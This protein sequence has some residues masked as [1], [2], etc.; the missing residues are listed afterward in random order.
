MAGVRTFTLIA[1]LG[2]IT[3]ILTR[4]FDNPF[5]IPAFGIAITALMIMSNF[6]KISKQPDTNVGQTTEMAVLL[7]F[8][9]GV[10]LVLG[11]Q[12]IAVIVGGTL[13]ILLYIK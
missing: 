12:V 6:M 5:I 13:A 9:V 10:Y 2:S 3:G 11:N 7:M 8:A 1:I 4:D